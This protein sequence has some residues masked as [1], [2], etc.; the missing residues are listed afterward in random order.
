V[1]RLGES[2]S[3]NGFYLCSAVVAVTAREY[4]VPPAIGLLHLPIIEFTVN[5]KD[6]RIGR[7]HCLT[8]TRSDGKKIYWAGQHN[9][10]YAFF[11]D[12]YRDRASALIRGGG[13]FWRHIDAHGDVLGYRHAGVD[14]AT[15]V[16]WEREID[17][18]TRL[19]SG[20]YLGALAV[21]GAIRHLDQIDPL[22]SEERVNPSLLNGIAGLSERIISLRT[23]AEEGAFYDVADIDID[24]VAG[25]EP[26]M[27]EGRARLRFEELKPDLLRIC[28]ASVVVFLTNS[29]ELI[30]DP[31]GA[32]S[33]QI[34][35]Y[36]DTE[37][38]VELAL[39]LV[40]ALCELPP[41]RIRE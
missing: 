32:A 34:P 2:F 27:D 26:M 15:A 11:F 36:I 3:E 20:R 9:L 17:V 31:S 7:G 1:Q 4:S 37:L 10:S 38:G 23:A 8:F 18:G 16:E 35:A 33:G 41:D 29:S 30:L 21:I 14:R 12:H 28:E 19:S 40:Q 6:Y 25:Y 13:V 24:I 5:G 22:S 39:E